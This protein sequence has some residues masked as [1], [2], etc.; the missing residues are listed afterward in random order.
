MAK[1]NYVNTNFTAGELSP[2]LMGRTDIAR[3]QNG[4]K[5]VR[6]AVPLIHGGVK[7][8][9]GTKYIA[10]AKYPDK[11]VRL[12]PFVSSLSD[13]YVL[14][15]GDYYM[16]VFTDGAQVLSAPSTPYE[17]A[18]VYPASAVADL[19]F[20]QSGDTMFLAHQS[21][22]PTR[23]R[24][25]SDSSWA[26]DSAPISPFPFDQNGVRP[27][28]NATL[29]AATV[30]AG[31]TLTA[32]AASFQAADVGRYVTAGP[33]IAIITGYTSTTVVTV[34]ITVAFSSTALTIEQW[35]L[36]GEPVATLT[37]SGSTTVIGG[38]A[39]LMLSA[40]GWR[41]TDVGFHVAINDGLVRITTYTSATAV[42]GEVIVPLASTVAAP[43]GAWILNT[44]SWSGAVG[45][46]RAVT[47]YQ[48]RLVYAGSRTFPSTI[49]G[50]ATGF[51]Y[52]FT[53]GTGDGDAF[54][55]KI[56]ASEVNPIRH[57]VSRDV[58]VAL[59]ERAEFTIQGGIERP[60][61]PT[62][63]QI[64]QRST[65]G[66][67]GVAP[68]TV[69][70]ES[71]YIQ[72][73]GRKVRAL[74]YDADSGGYVAP[75]IAV[76]AEHITDTGIF[77]TAYQ[78]EYDSVLWC[79]RGDGDMATCSLDRDQDVVGWARQSTDGDFLDVCAIPDG[80][81]DQVWCV[82]LRDIDG[83]VPTEQRY[84]ELFSDDV[85]LDCAITGT[86]GGGATVWTGL[87]HLE[88]VAVDCLADGVVLGPFIVQSGQ[89]ELEDAA[90][91]VVIGL[92][93]TSTLILLTPELP[94]VGSF[95]GNPMRSNEIDIRF[96][97]TE[98]ASVDGNTVTFESVPFTGIYRTENTG[99]SGATVSGV[100]QRGV[101]EV[102]IQ[103]A[104]PLPWHVLSVARKLSVNEP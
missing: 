54:A 55:F 5:V 62:N 96:L 87:D 16:R 52:D 43:T 13:A 29:S 98:S 44:P 59:T 35:V 88:G 8:R 66:S 90:N 3:Y 79:V 78:Q 72:R 74:K 64:K 18:T 101:N 53:I 22:A 12:I 92:P 39:T 100:W 9:P 94:G 61:T 84:I 60:L 25:F 32:S 99:W 34:T 80:D 30:G 21:Y 56:S 63:V 26:F 10:A 95:Q 102:T 103:Q 58:L 76:L 48:Q 91:D 50:S 19:T 85:L 2:R 75:D 70:D 28:A 1:F 15:F 24:R 77:S 47:L 71:L 27:G 104:D 82:V 31:R 65:Y 46:P 23:L 86:S 49:W 38:T 6:N 36:E 20:A 7:R 40:A 4:A 14:E 81:T 41:S 17:I 69:R 73:G 11:A 51:P 89:I 83:L 67:E 68:I 42:D 45:Y 37:P 93:Y 97:E 33:G 57:V